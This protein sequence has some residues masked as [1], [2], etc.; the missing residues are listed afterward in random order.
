MAPTFLL[1]NVAYWN[2]S[3]HHY[4]HFIQPE[5][6]LTF[7]IFYPLNSIQ[8]MAFPSYRQKGCEFGWEDLGGALNRTYSMKKISSIKVKKEKENYW[9]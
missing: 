6:F 8:M 2:V 5:I 3:L 4:G 1:I 9:Y 7:I